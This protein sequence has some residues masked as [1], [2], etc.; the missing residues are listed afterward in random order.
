MEDFSLPE[1]MRKLSI[2]DANTIEKIFVD[3]DAVIE[4]VVKSMCR[5]NA[6]TFWSGHRPLPS[7]DSDLGRTWEELDAMNVPWENLETADWFL[8][9]YGNLGVTK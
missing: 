5:S 1:S 6:F 8:L 4:H 2:Q 7:A 9:A 3:F